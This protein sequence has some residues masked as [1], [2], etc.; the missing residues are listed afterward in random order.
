M[1]AMVTVQMKL[2]MSKSIVEQK[3]WLLVEDDQSI[4]TML[5]AMIGFW[6]RIPLAFSDGNQAMAWLDDVEKG[7]ETSPLPE[8][9]LLD[10]RMPGPHGDEIAQRLRNVS[11]TANTPIVLMTAFRFEPDEHKRINETARPDAFIAK[12]LPSPDDFRKML[13]ELLERKKQPLPSA[14]APKNENTPSVPPKDGDKH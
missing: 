6:N 11:R 1:E 2:E 10:I 3:I 8:L 7:R 9:A 5:S 14:D 13:E 12:P 4:R